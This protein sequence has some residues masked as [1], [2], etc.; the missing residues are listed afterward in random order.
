MQNV[1]IRTVLA[2][3][4]GERIVVSNLRGLVCNVVSVQFNKERNDWQLNLD[5]GVH[6]MS[7]VML[8]DENKVWYRYAKVN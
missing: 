1:S 5:W 8:H 4:V 3:A 7:A 6:G 2:P